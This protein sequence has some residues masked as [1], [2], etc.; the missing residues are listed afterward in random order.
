MMPKSMYNDP[1][2][3]G[4]DYGDGPPLISFEEEGTRVL[5]VIKRMDVVKT[6]WKDGV[7]RYEIDDENQGLVVVMA[8]SVNL[9]GQLK[10]L[11]PVEG[12]R[13]DILFLGYRETNNG[14]MKL[15]DVNLVGPEAPKA[16]EPAKAPADDEEDIFS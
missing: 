2:L 1:R 3:A 15:F 7:L 14:Q 8:S 11:E 6:R 4:D 5:G 10:T 16:P 12:D 9:A 13:V